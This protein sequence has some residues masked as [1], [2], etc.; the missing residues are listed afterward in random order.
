MLDQH[1]G[2]A[3]LPENI[4]L[5]AGHVILRLPTTINVEAVNRA[6][7]ELMRP[8][9]LRSYLATGEGQERLKCAGH[10]PDLWFYTQYALM[11]TEPR[12]S[13]AQ[14]LY[15]FRPRRE[16]ATLIEALARLRF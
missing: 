9:S 6:V 5:N 16:A 2:S 10:A 1:L 4:R 3:S 14:E 13:A 8:R 11:T 7:H 12:L 15:L